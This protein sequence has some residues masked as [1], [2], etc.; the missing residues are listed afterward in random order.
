MPPLR[1]RREDIVPL[2]E[3]FLRVHPPRSGR[4]GYQ[5]DRGAEAPARATTGPATSASWQHVIERAVILSREPPLRLGF[6]TQASSPPAPVPGRVLRD[7]ELRAFERENIVQALERAGWRVGGAG[8]AAELLGI[9]PSTLR[10]RMK[11]FE[12]KRLEPA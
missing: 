2:A 3:H 5:L 11:V 12:I 4:S 7:G 1:E 10:D 6:L 8:G 9:S